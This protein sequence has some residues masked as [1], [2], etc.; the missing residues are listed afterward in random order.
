MY[1]TEDLVYI[2]RLTSNEA[3]TSDKEFLALMK[4]KHST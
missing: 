4:V 3:W 1:S 2:V